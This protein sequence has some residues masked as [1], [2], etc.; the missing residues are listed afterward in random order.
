MTQCCAVDLSHVIES[1]MITHP[2][3][4]TPLICDYLTRA[5][6]RV[7]YSEGVEFQISR[8][9]MVANTGTYIDSPFHRFAE[10]TDISGLAL[11]GLVDLRCVIVRIRAGSPRAV[12]A[13]AFSNEDTRLR[14]AR[15]HRV[16]CALAEAGVPGKQPAA[17][18]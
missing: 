14:S 6:S 17:Y 3:M 11:S 15:S 10:G 4:P 1:G 5:D 2:G 16:G 9:D 18:G 12:T 7:R 13:E 8:I